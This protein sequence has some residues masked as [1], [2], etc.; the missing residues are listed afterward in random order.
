MTGATV[1]VQQLGSSIR[2]DIAE[3]HMFQ[4]LLWL[5]KI[6]SITTPGRSLA[7]PSRRN[8]DNARLLLLVGLSN[9]G[10]SDHAVSHAD[11]IFEVLL[12]A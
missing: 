2:R 7:M 1:G 4:G 8:R 9:F 11:R 3:E 6:K 10:P 5:L 12:G